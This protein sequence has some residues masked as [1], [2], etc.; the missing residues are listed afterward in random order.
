MN[1]V[2]LYRICFKVTFSI[3]N[4]LNFGKNV[5]TGR[6]GTVGTSGTWETLQGTHG[7]EYW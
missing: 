2:I 1:T 3:F 7:K 4:M 6:E 5:L